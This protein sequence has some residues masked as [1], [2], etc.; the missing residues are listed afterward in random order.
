MRSEV[1]F[2]LFFFFTDFKLQKFSQDKNKTLRSAQSHAA[3][4]FRSL[5]CGPRPS[6]TNFASSSLR[7]L[8][9]SSSFFNVSSFLRFHPAAECRLSVSLHFSAF[10]TIALKFPINLRGAARRGTI[11]CEFVSAVIFRVRRIS[12]TNPPRLPLRRHRMDQIEE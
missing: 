3:G 11:R 8:N 4:A 9:V 6:R 2:E 10:S 7:L 5:S 12:L 1:R